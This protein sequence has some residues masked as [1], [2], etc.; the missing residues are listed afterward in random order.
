MDSKG[1][2]LKNMSIGLIGCGWLGKRMANKWKSNNTLYTTTTSINKIQALEVA[3]LQPTLINFEDE[4]SFKSQ[5]PWK[6]LSMLDVIIITIPISIRRNFNPDQIEFKIKNLASFISGYDKQVIFTSTTSVYP[7]TKQEF[8]EADVPV[9]N[10]FVENLICKHFPKANLLRLGGLMGDNRQLSNYNVKNIEAP[11]NHV[12]YS[13][14]ISVS[15]QLISKQLHNTVYNVVAPLHPS[16]QEV[17]AIQQNKKI[18]PV[19]IEGGRLISSAKL[20][21]E[22]EY[23]FIHPDPRYFH[24]TK[25]DEKV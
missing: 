19:K 3:G 23:A 4:K 11:V 7:N 22:L 1:S 14:V 16:K 5:L 2:V 24:I 9:Q 18:E 20:I 21:T 8:R 13:D 25:T 12:H 15:E 17:I 10:A 6:V